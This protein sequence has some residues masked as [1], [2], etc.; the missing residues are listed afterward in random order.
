MNPKPQLEEATFHFTQESNCLNPNL[1]EFLEIK[2]R[3]DLGIDRLDGNCFYELKTEGWSIDSLDELQEL[4][5]R[6]NK[7]IKL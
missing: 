1:A 4:F 2:C 6:I 5:D 7:A 3:A